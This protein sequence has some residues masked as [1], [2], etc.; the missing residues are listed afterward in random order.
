MLRVVAPSL[1]MGTAGLF[2]YA[3][4]LRKSSGGGPEA[5]RRRGSQHK[6][7]PSWTVAGQHCTRSRMCGITVV[8]KCWFG[9]TLLV[10]SSAVYVVGFMVR[11][12]RRSALRSGPDTSA[13]PTWPMIIRSTSLAECSSD[14]ATEP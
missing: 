11:L 13:S 7:E 14:L 2:G 3:P 1:I 4:P 6:R 9:F 5:W 8:M 12:S 10:N